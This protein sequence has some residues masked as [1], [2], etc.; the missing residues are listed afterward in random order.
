VQR[1][2]FLGHAVRALVEL[3]NG[4][5]VTAQ[6]PRAAGDGLDEGRAVEIGWG[7]EDAVLL[8]APQG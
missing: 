5:V 6:L 3:E 8:R 1:V 2:V 7:V 4:T